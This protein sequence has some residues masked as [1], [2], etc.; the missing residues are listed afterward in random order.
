M[1]DAPWDFVAAE[2]NGAVHATDK[3]HEQNSW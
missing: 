1:V 3:I 2:R